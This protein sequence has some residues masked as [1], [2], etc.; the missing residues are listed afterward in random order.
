MSR[1]LLSVNRQPI[2]LTVAGAKPTIPS[3]SLPTQT[4]WLSTDI[5]KGEIAWNSTDDIFYYRSDGDKILWLGGNLLKKTISDSAITLEYNEP[6][7]S[8][9]DMYETGD[10]TINVGTDNHDGYSK[11]LIVTG[12]D[13]STVTFGAGHHDLGANAF[14]DFDNSKTNMITLAFLQGTVY[15]TIINL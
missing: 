10:I 6:E 4:G 11:T 15:V 13:I 12:D 9:I 5:L 8:E 3:V 2:V 14:A 1:T 7:Y